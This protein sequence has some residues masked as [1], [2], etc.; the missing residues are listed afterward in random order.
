[1]P[2]ISQTVTGLS[3]WDGD[4]DRGPATLEWTDGRIT[5][6]TAVDAPPSEFSVIPG[7]IDT[8]VHLESSAT[9]STVDWM[10]W[11]LITP[12]S[13]RSLHVVAHARTAAASGVTTLR[14][15]AGGDA[16]FAAAR[17]LNAGLMPGP[18][19][20]VH[21]PVG[22]TAGH[23]DL[24]VPPHYPHRPPV[25]D[26]PDEC[27]KLVREWARAGADGIKIFTSGGVLS[28]GDKVGWR[29]QTNAEIAAT[30]DEA[31]A[32]GMLVAAHTHTAEGVDIALEFEV[33]SLEHGTGIQ[34]RHW[35][36]L[37]ERNIPVAPTLLINDAI[38]DRRIRVSDE[39]AEKARAVVAERDANFA[40]AGAAGIRFVL[41][42][43]A[44]G[45]MVRFGDQ[46]EEL[47]LM[48]RAFDWTAERALQA[49]TSDAAD[50]LRLTGTTGR[51]Q[52]GLGA[53]FVV[54]RGRP[55]EDIDVL[56][57]ENIVAVVA[58]GQLVAGAIPA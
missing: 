48:K 16:Q 32:L 15:L 40:G 21:G 9:P 34:P 30:V 42:T 33:D 49:G 1:M 18:R 52:P 5:A 35:D 6:V 47:R 20:L 53:D 41:G 45:I 24:F 13:E 25:A 37:L 46:L 38:A 58:R 55:W 27:R 3:V 8:H 22:M 19:L 2:A 28:I 56:T 50:A 39:A 14:D 54:V 43:D 44:N 36:T 29:N 57:A 31:H 23:G 51:L 10:T 17:G 4:L 11:P 26:S 7:L 12:A